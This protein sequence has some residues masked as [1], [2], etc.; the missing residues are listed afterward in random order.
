MLAL[1][2]RI[3]HDA[4]QGSFSGRQADRSSINCSLARSHGIKEGA[5]AKIDSQKVIR[6]LTTKWANRPCL[7]CNAAQWSV[8]DEAF[9]LRAF[10]DGNLIV[11]GALIPVVPVVCTN[12]GNT[13]LVNAIIAGA[14]NPQGA[15]QP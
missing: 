3:T 1:G 10:S 14:V 4:M 8:Q 7:M 9:E 11:G 15:K 6:H 12:C 2:R 5:V 13:V